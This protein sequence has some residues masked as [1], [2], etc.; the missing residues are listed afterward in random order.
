MHQPDVSVA[1]KEGFVSQDTQPRLVL[2]LCVLG[3]W[4]GVGGCVLVCVFARRD[5]HL[6]MFEV[7]HF[8]HTLYGGFPISG[9]KN[10][11]R[12]NKIR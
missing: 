1:S 12:H 5:R 2:C 7:P 8:R 6:N 11:W 10:S 4:L 3:G 9:D